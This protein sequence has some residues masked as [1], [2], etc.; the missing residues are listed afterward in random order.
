VAFPKEM[1]DEGFFKN[2]ERRQINLSIIPPQFASQTAPPLMSLLKG[3]RKNWI[4]RD[5]PIFTKKR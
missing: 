1:T 3:G 4:T 2:A 5:C